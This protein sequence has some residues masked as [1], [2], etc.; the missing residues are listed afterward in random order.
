MKAHVCHKLLRR[1]IWLARDQAG[2]RLLVINTP[3]I[4]EGKMHSCLRGILISPSQREMCSRT[5]AC[6]PVR[7]SI[8]AAQHIYSSTLRAG[9]ALSIHGEHCADLSCTGA[10]SCAT[11]MAGMPASHCDVIAVMALTWQCLSKFLDC[12]QSSPLDKTADRMLFQ[13]IESRPALEAISGMPRWGT[14]VAT[15]LLKIESR[16]ILELC[17]VSGRGWK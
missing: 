13:Q 4:G 15:L 2:C 3:C 14:M 11:S 9:G 16:C 6:Q 12:K 8:A 7:I 17:I 1:R 5:Y 10:I